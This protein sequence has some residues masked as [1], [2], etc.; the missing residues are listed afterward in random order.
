MA[1][2]PITIAQPN[3]AALGWPNCGRPGRARE[4]VPWPVQESKP[5]KMS[6]PIPA[7]SSPGTST[8]PSMGPPRPDAS[9]SRKALL[10]GEPKSVLTAA[11][12]PAAPITLMLCSGRSRLAAAVRT[13]ATARPPP[14]AMSGASGPITAP[15]ARPASAASATPGSSAREGGPCMAK[16]S[17]GECPPRPGRYWMVSPTR[18]PARATAGNGHQTGSP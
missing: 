18:S 7:A 17:A 8:S 4:N 16:P 10:R 9:I 2:T 3:S 11:K 15:R 14:M 12:L 5:T 1:A 13:R 6:H